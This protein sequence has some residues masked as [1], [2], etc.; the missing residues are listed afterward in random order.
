[1]LG[2][3]TEKAVPKKNPIDQGFLELKQFGPTDRHSPLLS[4][5]ST[6]AR[7]QTSLLVKVPPATR[8]CI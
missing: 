8:R 5:I 1:M 7:Y 4:V 6:D 3:N 2:R